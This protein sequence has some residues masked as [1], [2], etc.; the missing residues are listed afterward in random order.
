MIDQIIAYVFN[1]ERRAIITETEIDQ[2]GN[3]QNQH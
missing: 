3:N 1:F 2:C